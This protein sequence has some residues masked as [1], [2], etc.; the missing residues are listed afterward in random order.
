MVGF[1]ATLSICDCRVPQL[2]N[3][4]YHVRGIVETVNYQLLN[5]HKMISLQ[6]EYRY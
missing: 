4:T 3:N 6:G 2:F 5:H 1:F